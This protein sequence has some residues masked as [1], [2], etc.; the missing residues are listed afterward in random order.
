MPAKSKL[1]QRLMGMALATKRGEMKGGSAIV[2]GLAESMSGKELKKFAGT[3][4]KG[5]PTK[6]KKKK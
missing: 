3:K 5:L 2:K 4:T 6:V 1:Q